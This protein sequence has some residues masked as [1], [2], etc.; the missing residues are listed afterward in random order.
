MHKYKIVTSG[1]APVGYNTTN[2]NTSK[3]VF[4]ILG[5]VNSVYKKNQTI[6]ISINQKTLNT[7]KKIDV[8]VNNTY[9]TSLKSYPYKVL[10]TPND[11]SSISTVN[12]IRAIGYDSLGN[13]G[14]TTATFQVEE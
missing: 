9:L 4:E 6:N 12:T 14:E 11:I 5:L 1:S 10:F 13:T 2:T 8:Y 7:I 3:P